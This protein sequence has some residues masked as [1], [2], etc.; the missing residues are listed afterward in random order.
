MTT[1]QRTTKERL[2]ALESAT[3]RL[4]TKK[5][6]ATIEKRLKGLEGWKRELEQSF[7]SIAARFP[8]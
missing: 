7:K 4:A 6:V 1:T 3:H 8:R 2:A 5:D